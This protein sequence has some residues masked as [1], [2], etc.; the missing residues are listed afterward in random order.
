MTRDRMP[1]IPDAERTPEQK[2]VL[3]SAAGRKFTQ[4]MARKFSECSELLLICL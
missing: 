3:L 1:G 4:S 2:V